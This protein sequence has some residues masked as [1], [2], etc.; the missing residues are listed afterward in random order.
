MIEDNTRDFQYDLEEHASDISNLQYDTVNNDKLDSELTDLREWITE[1]EDKILE[2]VKLINNKLADLF[3][4]AEP[5][6]KELIAQERIDEVLSVK[7]RTGRYDIDNHGEFF[8]REQ[9]EAS[10]SLSDT[11]RKEI[12]QL[13]MTLAEE[14]EFIQFNKN[15]YK[16]DKDEMGFKAGKKAPEKKLS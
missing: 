14:E 8:L 16:G 11:A 4:D 6:K 12:T 9:D 7:I 1:G 15:T 5:E 2:K 3:P 10:I 13:L